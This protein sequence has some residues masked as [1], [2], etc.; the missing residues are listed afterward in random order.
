VSIDIAL[1]LS[2]PVKLSSSTYC[3]GENEKSRGAENAHTALS[4]IND[5]FLAHHVASNVFLFISSLSMVIMTELS[6]HSTFTNT[7]LIPEQSA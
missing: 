2:V 5:D 3:Y 4:I 6:F 7:S 1:K